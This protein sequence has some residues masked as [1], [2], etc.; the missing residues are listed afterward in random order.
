MCG[1]IGVTGSREPLALLLKG[2]EALEYRGYDSAG[3]ALVDDESGEIYVER[4]AEQTRS[5]EKLAAKVSG[6]SSTASTGIGHTRWATHGAPVEQNAHP[7]LDCDA[8]VAIVHNGIIE[9]HLELAAEL[10]ESGHR[11]RSET[12]TEVV[13]HLIEAEIGKGSSLRDAVRTTVAKLRGDFAFAVVSAREPA[14]IVAARRTS[15]LV[16]GLTDD[17]GLIASDISALLDTTRRL[18]TLDDDQIVEIGPG[19]F[20]AQDISGRTISL[21]PLEVS[22]NVEDARRE[23]FPDFMSK[24][25]HEQFRAVEQTLL[26]RVLGDGTTRIEELDIDPEELASFSRVLLLGCGSSYHAALAGR[27][28]MEALAG[29]HADADISSE[30]RYRNSSVGKETLVVAISQSGETVDSLHAVR[31]ARSRGAT[32]ITVSNVVDSVMARESDGACYTH[33][34]PEVGVA[35][36][37]S[38]VAQLAILQVLALHVAR[39]RSSI[40]GGEAARFAEQLRAVP[41]LVARAVD[42]FDE[43]RRV[44]RRFAS[45]NDVYF[46]GRRSGLPIAMEGALKLKELAYVRAEAYPAGEMKHGP[47]SLIEPGVVVVAVATRNPLWEKVV[48]NVQEM[49]ARGATIVAI[50]DEGDEETV[51]LADAVLQVPPTSELLSPIVA[52]VATQS[53]AYEIAS[54]RGRNVDRP[55]NLAKVVTVE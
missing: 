47:I 42:S 54:A 50:C 52:A 2:L 4:S 26:G 7:Q 51:Q 8:Q 23:G 28:S 36:T 45:V 53:F 20:E 37:K 44:A 10:A 21:R 48:G 5:V 25:I 3:V 31:E 40:D 24:E 27:Q 14:T 17:Q 38:H 12:D 41:H 9:N 19:R 22:W 15:P 39:A 11:F 46:L 35:S 16:V 18:F 32:V 6:A 55:R 1:I 43:Y 30:F 49:R 34:G 33:A 13:A 29:V